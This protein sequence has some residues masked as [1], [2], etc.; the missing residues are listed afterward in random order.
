[1]MKYNLYCAKSA[2][3]ARNRDGELIG[4]EISFPRLCSFAHC[5]SYGLKRG[6]AEKLYEGKILLRT[7]IKTTVYIWLEEAMM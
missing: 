1:M 2:K 4:S 7:I 6:D 5:G 3:A